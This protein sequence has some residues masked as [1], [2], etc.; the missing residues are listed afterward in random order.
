MTATIKSRQK[1]PYQPSALTVW[2]GLIAAAVLMAAPMAAARD[3]GSAS[4]EATLRMLDMPLESDGS[5]LLF[6][7]TPVAEEGQR[8]GSAPAAPVKAL[9]LSP[10]L[11]AESWARI[12]TNG[13]RDAGVMP[14]DIN[15]AAMLWLGLAG[16]AVA[17]VARLFA[18][19]NRPL[20][21]RRPTPPVVA[22][23]A[24]DRRPAT[25]RLRMQPRAVTPDV[26]EG[27]APAWSALSIVGH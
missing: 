27:K 7:L 2:T 11:A 9:Q 6:D 20:S 21:G 17:L 15:P 16:I 24:P 12:E 14:L 4:L 5:A 18:R 10:Q 13:P 22:E 19:R 8:S 1:A 25:R 26:L 23:S 3:S